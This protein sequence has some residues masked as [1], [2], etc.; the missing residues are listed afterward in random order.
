M[1]LVS[2]SF[3]PVS[4]YV[5]TLRFNYCQQHHVFRSSHLKIQNVHFAGL[6]DVQNILPADTGISRL[7]EYHSFGD[8]LISG[9][10]SV[11]PECDRSFYC[12]LFCVFMTRVSQCRISLLSEHPIVQDLTGKQK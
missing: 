8:H 1:K 9:S 2:M 11:T 3:S 6:L 5:I 10:V 12:A 7:T 4:C